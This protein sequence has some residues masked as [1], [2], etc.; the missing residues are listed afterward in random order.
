[1]FINFVQ[2]SPF[3]STLNINSRI[4]TR[5]VADDIVCVVLNFCCA[6]FEIEKLLRT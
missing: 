1:M 5:P 6:L 2:F 4:P 3:N